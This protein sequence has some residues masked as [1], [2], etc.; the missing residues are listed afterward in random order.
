MN[1]DFFFNLNNFTYKRVN[2]VQI[3]LVDL[4]ISEYKWI[5][6]KN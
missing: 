5:Y 3:K 6:K 2:A 4:I 1:F